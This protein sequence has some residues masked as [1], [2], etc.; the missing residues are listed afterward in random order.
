MLMDPKKFAELE[1]KVLQVIPVQGLP[2][3]GV[4]RAVA[5]GESGYGRSDAKAAVLGLKASGKV[6]LDE[7]GTVRRK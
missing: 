7:D 3:S 5:T 6:Q 4:V 2:L 1:E